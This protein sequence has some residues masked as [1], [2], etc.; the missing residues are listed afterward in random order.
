M[1]EAG[2]APPRP[3]PPPVGD[4]REQL[5]GLLDFLRATVVW[6][7]RGLTDA[8]ARRSLVGSELT[9]V[10]NLV[11]HLRHTE[12]FWFCVVLD[13]RP[14]AWAHMYGDEEYD[15]RRGA[16]TPLA[17]LIAEYQAQCEISREIAAARPLDHEVWHGER[18][19]NARWIVL[20]L[21]DETARHAGH[22]DLLREMLDGVTGE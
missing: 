21:I 2:Q 3:E 4:E 19:F 9:T 10:A 1:G 12:E 18:R 8:Q 7:S 16:R 14:D 15:F 6:K 20:H 17:Q 5:T 22:L 13:G 11:A